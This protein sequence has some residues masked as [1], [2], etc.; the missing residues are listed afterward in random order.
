MG[1]LSRQGVQE[2]IRAAQPT[3]EDVSNGRRGFIASIFRAATESKPTP[4]LT[5]A[6]MARD[7]GLI[8]QGAG[9]LRDSQL[10]EAEGPPASASAPKPAAP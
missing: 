2:A 1:D 7:A 8:L 6:G 10:A 4:G 9:R 5:G 3:G